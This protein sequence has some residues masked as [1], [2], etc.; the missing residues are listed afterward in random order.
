MFIDIAFCLLLILLLFPGPR[1]ELVA[2]LTVLASGALAS[3]PVAPALTNVT[4]QLLACISPD[5]RVVGVWGRV[6]GWLG[7]SMRLCVRVC[8]MLSSC[9][10]DGF[11]C[12]YSTD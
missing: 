5:V 1:S 12:R 2:R 4:R 9:N 3:P 10:V 8:P 7:V 6:G 11:E